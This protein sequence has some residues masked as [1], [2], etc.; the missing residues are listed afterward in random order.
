MF[1]RVKVQIVSVMHVFTNQLIDFIKSK[2]TELHIVECVK[3][4]HEVDNY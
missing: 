3:F 4:Y 1:N 2:F